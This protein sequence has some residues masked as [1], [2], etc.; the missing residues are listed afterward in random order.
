RLPGRSGVRSPRRDRGRSQTQIRDR[1]SRARL[2]RHQPTRRRD[3]SGES[4]WRRN[5]HGCRPRRQKLAHRK[6]P[7]MRARPYTRPYR[8]RENTPSV[9]PGADLIEKAENVAVREILM[10]AIEQVQDIPT[11]RDGG[12]YSFDRSPRRPA[13][14]KA[15]ALKVLRQLRDETETTN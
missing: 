12:G 4:I 5:R 11:D 3:P 14:V 1:Q 9:L 15:D 10:R 8:I 13:D 2:H 6:G 7:T